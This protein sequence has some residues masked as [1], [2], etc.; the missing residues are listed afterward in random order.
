MYINKCTVQ[1]A[2]CFLICNVDWLI[3]GFSYNEYIF[4][5]TRI[6][7]NVFYIEILKLICGYVLINNTFGVRKY[8]IYYI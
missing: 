4:T 3:I 5:L 1:H 6:F 8:F 7:V 2:N